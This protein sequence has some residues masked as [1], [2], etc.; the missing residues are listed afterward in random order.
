MESRSAPLL[1]KNPELKARWEGLIP[2]RKMG[3]PEDLMGAVV[4]LSSEASK[5]ITG[6]E[7]KVD[8]GFTST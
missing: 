3:D 6:I 4:F 2:Q 1:V 8:G 5:Y 7:I